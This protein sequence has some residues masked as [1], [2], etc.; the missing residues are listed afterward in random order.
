VQHENNRL[1][2][3]ALLQHPADGRRMH[4]SQRA[5]GLEAGLGAFL[6]DAGEQAAGGLRVEDLR[7]Y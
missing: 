2:R 5:Q 4:V 7:V 3:L 6:R 1:Q